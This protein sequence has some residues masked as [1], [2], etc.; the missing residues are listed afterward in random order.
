MQL[1]DRK[2]KSIIQAWKDHSRDSEIL[3]GQFKKE[4]ELYIYNFPRLAYHKDPDFCSDFYL[5]VLE[6]LPSILDNYPLDADIQFKTWFNYVLRNKLI[7]LYHKQKKDHQACLD[8]DDYQDSFRVETFTDEEGDFQ[9]LKQGL[10]RLG[11][12]DRILIQFYYLPESLDASQIQQAATLFCLPLHRV[13]EIRN[14]MMLMHQQDLDRIRELSERL[15][16]LYTRLRDK[17]HRLYSTP[18]LGPEEQN[19]LLIQ[20]SRLEGSR[21]SLLHRIYAPNNKLMK[22]FNLLFDNLHKA[23]Y[24]LSIAQKK[25]RFYLLQEQRA[26]RQGGLL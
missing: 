25:L 18:G 2:I 13:L 8:L 4:I 11:D 12:A 24:R 10:S 26:I 23:R 15:Q 9:D 1:H 21:Y 14:Q 6:Q 5:Y 22:T 20:I 16:S 7:D 17:K 19:N 3:L